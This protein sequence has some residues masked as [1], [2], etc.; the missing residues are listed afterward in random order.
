M[1]A[2]S[3]AAKLGVANRGVK[4]SV[5]FMP[6][7]VY[8][9]AACIRRTLEAAR[10][11]DFPLESL[12]FEITETEKVADSAHLQRITDEYARHGITMALDDFGA[13]CSGFTSL[14]ELAGIR[15]LKID[16]SL[17]RRID[18]RPRAQYVVKKIIAMCQEFGIDVLG[19]C[20]ETVVHHPAPLRHPADAGIP[21][22]KPGLECYPT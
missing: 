10:E 7:D 20:V 4:L 18:Q 1:S 9:P 22:R 16:G 2:I 15:L 12:I 14:T 19:E 11:H 3:L 8:S 17:I 5:N 21:V 6:G 13:G